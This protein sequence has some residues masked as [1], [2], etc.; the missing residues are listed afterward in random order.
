M[1]V[2]TADSVAAVFGWKNILS[3]ETSEALRHESS[4]SLKTQVSAQQSIL[5][6]LK[7]EAEASGAGLRRAA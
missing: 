1:V 3:S 5:S 4:R 2:S 7:L 6:A